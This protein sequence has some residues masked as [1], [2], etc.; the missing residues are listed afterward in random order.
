MRPTSELP[1]AEEL[2]RLLRYDP[3]SGKV[4]WRVGRLKGR[5]A[6]SCQFC[7]GGQ[8]LTHQVGIAGAKFAT[9]RVIW[10]MVTGEEPAGSVF[11]KNFNRA[12]LRWENLALKG[13]GDTVW[14]NH[15][16][17][18]T[19]SGFLG[20]YRKGKNWMARVRGAD[21]K[22]HYLGIFPSIEDA[23]KAVAEFDRRCSPPEHVP[24]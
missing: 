22:L 23:A 1:P 8:F 10:K 15:R 18:R 14:R 4:F 3:E 20:V 24:G 6:G 7:Y 5:E 19:G 13:H 17:V 21:S 12:D 16:P 11:H 2:N 9:A